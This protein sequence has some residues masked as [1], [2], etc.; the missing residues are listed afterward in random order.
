LDDI[1]DIKYLRLPSSKLGHEIVKEDRIGDDHHGH[2]HHVDHDDDASLH[3]HHDPTELRYSVFFNLEDLK[4]GLTK[5]I[6]F[7]KKKHSSPL[8]PRQSAAS[9]PFSLKQLPNILKLFSLPQ[10]S[11]EAKAAEFTLR[12]CES[13]TVMG[14]IR[15]C[16]T[17]FE[18]ML[19]FIRSIFGMENIGH[20]LTLLT[21]TFYNDSKTFFQNYT[22]LEVPKEIPTPKMVACH[23]MEFP[24]A[25][26]GCHTQMSDRKVYKI[27]LRGEKGDKVVAI[28]VCHMDTSEWEPN[29]PSFKALGFGPGM[30]PVCHFF[31]DETNLLWLP[32]TVP[33]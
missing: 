31:P 17:S 11:P 28:A 13:K 16:A 14:E 6:Y 25:V 15:I 22:V 8:L 10:G 33:V 20:G 26:Y 19:D 5:P 21:T 2:M 1:N 12:M 7:P 3:T 9:V 29:H 27:S 24:Y 32:S 18:S 4:V 30:A 23:L